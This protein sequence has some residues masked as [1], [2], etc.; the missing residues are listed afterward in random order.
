MN[1]NL[2]AR[3]LAHEVDV[4]WIVSLYLQIHGGDPAERQNDLTT[5]LARALVTQIMDRHHELDENPGAVFERLSRLGIR[6]KG[7][8]GDKEK[9]EIELRTPQDLHHYAETLLAVGWQR[10]S[11]I[12]PAICLYAEGFAPI[13]HLLYAAIPPQTEV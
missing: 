3:K 9:R 2:L 12:E 13:C 1:P 6:F 7:R 8:V 5:L 4:A 11:G 10:G